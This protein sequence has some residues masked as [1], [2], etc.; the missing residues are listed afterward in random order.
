M[1]SANNRSRKTPKILHNRTM[2]LELVDFNLI[3]DIATLILEFYSGLKIYSQLIFDLARLSF[4]IEINLHHYVHEVLS[5]LASKNTNVAIVHCIIY[6]FLTENRPIRIYI[7][8]TQQFMVC[9]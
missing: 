7:P 8:C 9:L 3:K 6:A 2:K 5:N 4:I 1:H